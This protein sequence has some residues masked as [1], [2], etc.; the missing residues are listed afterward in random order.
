MTFVTRTI[1]AL[2]AVFLPI[3]FAKNLSNPMPM[4]PTGSIEIKFSESY[5]ENA[6]GVSCKS[7]RITLSRCA[8]VFAATISLVHAADSDF[9][10]L[11]D[12]IETNTGVYVSASN[13]GTDPGAADTDGDGVPDGL[14]VKEGTSPVDATKF[15]SFSQ[16]LVGYYQFNS[17]ANDLSGKSNSG[18]TSNITYTSDRLGNTESAAKYAANS[19]MEIPSLTLTELNYR[20]VTYSMWIKL[21]RMPEIGRSFV[22]IGRIRTWD[23]EGGAVTILNALGYDNELCYYTGGRLISSGFKPKIDQWYNVMFTQTSQGLASFYIDGYLVH[24]TDFDV[25]QNTNFPFRIGAASVLD[26]IDNNDTHSFQGMIDDVRIYNRALSNKE[27]S[28]LY[29]RESFYE[30]IDQDGLTNAFETSLGSDPY[31]SDTDGDG[32][33]D[34]LEVKEKTSPVDATKFNSFSKG[35][36]AYYPLDKSGADETGSGYN[37]NFS[38][39][40]LE[41]VD[42]IKS[43]KAIGSSPSGLLIPNG[44][45]LALTATGWAISG[46]I[47]CNDFSASPSPNGYFTLYESG[48]VSGSQQSA[49]NLSYSAHGLNMQIAG[50]DDYPSNTSYLHQKFYKTSDATSDTLRAGQWHHIMVVVSGTDISAFVDGSQLIGFTRGGSTWSG[51]A[52]KLTT[53]A[54]GIGLP[55]QGGSIP[56]NSYIKDVR[57]YG[58]SLG[59]SEVAALSARERPK[60]QIING[61]YTWQQA[62][63]DAEARGGRL[64][65]LDTQAKIDHSVF[66]TNNPTFQGS[67]HIGLQDLSLTGQWKWIDGSNLSASNWASGE[68][69][70]YQGRGET[71]AAIIPTYGGSWADIRNDDIYDGYILEYN[72]TNLVISF[73]DNGTV[74]GSGEYYQGATA[75]LTAVPD[76]GYRFTGW[77]GDASGTQNPLTI[78]MDADKTVGATFDK[79]V[80]DADNDGLTA[81]EELVTYSTNPN[82]VDTDGDGINDGVE[83]Q[84]GRSPSIAEPVIT[85]VVATQRTGTKFF[86]ISYD[87][88]STTPTAKMSLEISSDGGATYNVPVTSATGAIGEGVA[89][90][91]GKSITWNAG[92]DWDAK[93]SSQMR[94]RLIADNQIIDGLSLIPAGAFTM[95]RTSGDTDTNA[96]PVTVNVSRFYMGKHEVTKALWDEVRTWAAANG[97]TD[98]A[99]GAGKAADHPVQMVSWWDV[100]KWC[101]ARSQKEGLTPCYTLSGSVM[102]TGTTAPTVDWGASGYRLPTEAEWE[103]AARGGMSGKRF[104]WGTDTISQSQANYYAS[105]SYSHDESGSENNYHPTYATGSLPYTSPVAAFAANAYGLHDMAG[106]VWEWCWDWY[107]ASTYVNGSTDP[108]GAT[109]GTDRIY[110]GGGWY[111]GA[112]YCRAANRLNNDPSGRNGGIGFRVTSSSG[113]GALASQT[114]T[115]TNLDTRMW[116]LTS[117][118]VENGSVSGAGSYLSQTSATLTATPL[119]GY[120]FGSWNGAASGSTNPTTILMNSSKTVGASFV[121]DTRDPDNDG[122]TNYQEIIIRLTNPNSADTDNDGVNDGQE[123]TD[124]TNPLVADSDGDG[125]TDSEEKTRTTNPLVVDTDG[126]GL[127][128][129]QEITI[130]QTNPLLSDTNGNGINDALEDTDNDGILNGREVNQLGTNPLLADT[131][132][133][134]LSDTYELLFQGNTDPFTPRVGDRVRYDLSQLGYQGTYKVVGTLPK[135]LTFNATTG[136]LEGKLIGTAGTS[137]LTIQILN[138]KTVLR[139]IPLNIPVLAFPA[140]LVGTW[141]TLL[142]NQQDQPEGLLT[143]TIT[144]PGTWSASYDGIGT[145]TLRKAKGSFDLTAAEEEASWSM[146]F[147]ASST[148]QSGL[149]AVTMSFEIVGKSAL[150]EGTHPRGT[151][152][153]FRLARG[154][155]LPAKTNTITML[156]DQGAQDGF[157]IPAGMGWATGSISNRGAVAIKGQLGD[158]QA[159]TTTLSLGATGQ[160]LMW[161]KPYKNLNSYI[162]GIVSLHGS[163]VLPASP[164]HNQESELW[165]YRAADAAELGYS[166]G[167]APISP[168]VGVRSHL[169]P[170]SALALSQNLGLTEQVIRGVAFDGGGLPD[171]NAVAKLPEAFAIDASYK[172]IAVPIP[173]QPMTP[174]TGLI[175]SR[176]GGFTGTL[177]VVASNSDT[178]AGN[179]AVSGV[180]FP[181]VGSRVVGAG[182]VKIPIVG[183]KGAFRTGAIMMGEDV[184]KSDLALIPAGAFQMGVTSGDTDPD[185][186]SVSVTVS[187]FY[188]GKNEVTKALWDEVQAWAAANGYTDLATGAGKASNHPVQSVSWW[189][190]VK[191]CNARSKKEGLTPCYT[192]DGA[193]MKTGTT[194]PT[195][196]WTA[197]GYRLPTEAEWEKAARG[198]VS[199]KRFPW[200]TDTISHSQA[201]YYTSTAYNYDASGSVNNYHPTYATGEFLYTSPVGSFDANG[202]GLNDMAGNVKEWCWDWYGSSTYVNGATDPRGAASATYRVFRGGSWSD[203]AYYC[204]AADRFSSDPAGRNS[205]IG[206]RIARSSVP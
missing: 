121:E 202:Y 37:G 151:M 50:F 56:N 137:K 163:G 93:S 40:S 186:P 28:Q 134:G 99:A 117:S 82:T 45:Q 33:P 76:P 34:G 3:G 84:Q 66:L 167:F 31:N 169:L 157:V 22:L 179:A 125:L 71:V 80:S 79:D 44:G 53:R 102:K 24:S 55:G 26:G 75:T 114:S 203:Y 162:G 159:I 25:S 175:A 89:I 16:G 195:V 94:F 148:L 48:D 77:T 91:T 116:T 155:E 15:N 35:L 158:A 98:M 176:T 183:P 197:N 74:P 90:G 119:S 133:N 97:Y 131:N 193:V 106:N 67:Y 51:E 81:Y 174:W 190:V 147:P 8:I 191:W 136:I 206:F 129:L 101:N 54:A 63:A 154:A 160:A 46:W 185:A 120:L 17:N 12:A 149:P 85:S 173:G 86:D 108:R 194:E 166:T 29:T 172:M 2:R 59:I 141:Q 115:D 124:T 49:I 73:H 65:V 145:R 27:I 92:V 161:L 188:M 19:I 52:P 83:V 118:S 142:E 78:T 41:S 178:I 13:A 100:V 168:F 21:D 139:S 180:L 165:W 60:F 122:L 112:I 150:A 20:P 204:R 39:S 181:T 18:V 205:D 196:D 68:P 57:I 109:S 192:V 200:G 69:Q 199:G 201:N 70:N 47:K 130:S 1:S 14:E 182:L 187:A 170:T 138:G 152:R 64:A 107:G 6:R 135:G 58:R 127:G 104:P 189:D 87:L 103:K 11:D 156:I 146:T 4:R 36:V 62:K 110:R 43:L 96:P 10:G 171:P 132:A 128:D 140:T 105:T 61:S 9:D 7:S 153:G 143:V 177:K 42:G 23:Q 184:V 38:N 123:I 126:D 95:G 72:I 5:A 113:N 198:G 32:V 88:S 111:D 164:L 30:D 144:S